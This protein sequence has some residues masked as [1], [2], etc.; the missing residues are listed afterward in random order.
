MKNKAAFV[1]IISI[2]FFMFMASICFAE[3]TG[4]STAT[5]VNEAYEG[6]PAKL[7]PA[8]TK[9]PSYIQ[10]W[11]GYNPTYTG[12]KEFEK[13]LPSQT[14]N[15]K[16]EEIYNS[17]EVG[18]NKWMVMAGEEALNAAKSGGGPFG[19]VIVQ[20]D[21]KTGKVIRY[22]KGHNHVTEWVDPSAHA[23]I[24]TIRTVCKELGV[25]DL[26]KIEKNKAKLPQTGE[27]SHCEIYSSTEPCPMC[28]A[29][30]C[31]ANIPVLIFSCTRYD[32][33]AQ[34]VNFSDEKIY[35]ELAKLYSKRTE[36]KVLQSSIPNSLDAFNYWKRSGTST[37]Y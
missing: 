8:V 23:E 2:L 28:Y 1:G 9:D 35:N 30:I 12:K 31:W 36:R 37:H 22:W 14:Y 29:T 11:N 20:I 4:K 6:V 27:T 13:Y 21:D 32:A 3:P 34:G 7:D 24:S 33:A 16:A 10:P 25:I 19:A 17:I 5:E 26:G 15:I 18:S